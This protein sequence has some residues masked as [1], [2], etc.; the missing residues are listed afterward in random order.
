MSGGTDQTSVDTVPQNPEA[1]QTP[2]IVTK[3]EE[4][5]EQTRDGISISG[6]EQEFVWQ[7]PEPCVKII[8]LNI[9]LN[10]KVIS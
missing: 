7:L 2:A 3:E 5:C 8:K 9:A 1:G 6:A 10:I 4:T